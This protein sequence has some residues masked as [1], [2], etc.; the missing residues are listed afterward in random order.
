MIA[1][2]SIGFLKSNHQIEVTIYGNEKYCIEQCEKRLWC[3]WIYIIEPDI[4]SI[5]TGYAKK[6][7][8][9]L[10]HEPF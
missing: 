3:T 2:T 6:D 5:L 9:I 4:F 7:T 8:C 1:S 10:F